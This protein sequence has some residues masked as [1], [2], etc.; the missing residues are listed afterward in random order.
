[1]CEQTK[2]WTRHGST[3]YLWKE[4]NVLTAIRYVLYDQG[5]P[6]EVFVDQ[7]LGFKL[8]NINANLT[9]PLHDGRGSDS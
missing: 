8:R 2:R 3:R 7:G 5:E 4:S 9:G 6:M 1:M